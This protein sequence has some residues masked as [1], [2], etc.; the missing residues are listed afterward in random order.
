MMEVYT[1]LFSTTDLAFRSKKKKEKIQS[2]KQESHADRGITP[3]Y[4]LI[5]MYHVQEGGGRGNL[6]QWA[7]MRTQRVGLG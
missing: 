6:P 5:L 1:H 7:V 3:S 4:P 2:E